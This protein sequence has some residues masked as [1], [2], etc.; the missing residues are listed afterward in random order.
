MLCAM[1]CQKRTAI[2]ALEGGTM[3]TNA[4]EEKATEEFMTRGE[5]IAQIRAIIEEFGLMP[6]EIYGEERI[7]AFADARAVQ[8]WR[9]QLLD[10]KYA[11]REPKNPPKYELRLFDARGLVRDVVTWSGRGRMPKAIE[12][13]IGGDKSRLAELEIK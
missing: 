2:N 1:H 12:W 11:K 6:N 13:H 5:A 4:T 7:A 10:E 8:K 3:T 9:N